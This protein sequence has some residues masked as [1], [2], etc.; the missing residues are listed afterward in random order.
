M[1]AG[2][3][4][5]SAAKSNKTKASGSSKPSP[6]RAATKSA[7]AAKKGGKA[8]AKAAPKK[9]TGQ[10]PV[11]KAVAKP[12]AKTVAKRPV[13]AASKPAK[14]AKQPKKGAPK[15]APKPA[16]KAPKGAA[17]PQPPKKGVKSAVASAKKAVITAQKAVV[18]TAK[19]VG[20][21]AKEV[22]TSKPVKTAAAVAA[23]AAVAAPA[24]QKMAAA[25]RPSAADDSPRKR[26]PRTRITSDGGPIANWIQPNAPKPRPSS[27]IPAPPRAESPSQI[28]A[29]PASSDRLF[30]PD[31]LEFKTLPAIRTFPVRVEIEQ[32]VGRTHV[33]V[34]PNDVVIRAGD[35]VEWDFR[36]LGGADTFID[37]IAIELPGK[38]YFAANKFR[39]KNP[40]TARPHRQLSGRLADT[41]PKGIVEYTIRCYAFGAELAHG[42]AK[43]TIT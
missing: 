23:V 40:G 3:K 30:R 6:K 9:K 20:H 28:A 39:S 13:K 12:A 21:A 38:Q 16:P 7:P 10:K 37:E 24:V 29:P 26:R 25:A 19:N 33:F 36:Y 22:M 18:K 15:A 41:A 32:A 35:G 4:S 17:K 27:F 1:P 43:L 2:K 14:S 11:K 42:T 31:D 34:Q 8:P 5:K